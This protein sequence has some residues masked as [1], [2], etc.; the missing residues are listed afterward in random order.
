MGVS[1]VDVVNCDDEVDAAIEVF[2]SCVGDD[3]TDPCMDNMES[4]NEEEGCSG[5]CKVVEVL[6]VVLATT[7][8]APAAVRDECGGVGG[9][10]VTLRRL[11]RSGDQDRRD[12]DGAFFF[13]GD[14]T[15]NVDIDVGVTTRCR[16]GGEVA[17]TTVVRENMIPS[18]ATRFLRG[19]GAC[20][21]GGGVVASLLLLLLLA[22]TTSILSSI[23]STWAGAA[24]LSLLSTITS[25]S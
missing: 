2:M 4:S 25:L 19:R 14:L 22:M 11:R 6:A 9:F 5:G 10:T 13:L 21:R 23:D 12:D 3:C 8:V 18:V 17:R 1:A 15:D 16:G 20:W 7:A 24:L